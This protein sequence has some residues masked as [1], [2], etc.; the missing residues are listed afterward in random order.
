MEDLTNEK[1]K[2]II[3]GVLISV[4]ST[5]SGKDWSARVTCGTPRVIS[6]EKIN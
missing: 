1:T 6:V 2:N 4:V 3:N 5:E